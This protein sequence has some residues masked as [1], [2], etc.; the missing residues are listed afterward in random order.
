M[1]TL[2]VLGV[3][4]V[5][6]GVFYLLLKQFWFEFSKIGSNASA[7][8][9]MMFL[10]LVGGITFF[11]LHRWGPSKGQRL[12]DNGINAKNIESANLETIPNLEVL[13]VMINR[14]SKTNRQLLME[15][16]KSPPSDGQYVSDLALN[17]NLMLSRGEIVYRG[18]ELESNGFLEILLLSDQSFRFNQSVLHLVNSDMELLKALLENQGV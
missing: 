1:R 7:I 16:A 3:P 18:K 4:G 5:A 11:A 13:K 10:I 2:V 12:N 6:L 15:V 17:E 8:I 14:L 9:A